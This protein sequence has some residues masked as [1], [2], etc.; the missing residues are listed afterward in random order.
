MTTNH[1]PPRFAI[2]ASDSIRNI[3]LS[4]G[5]GFKNVLFLLNKL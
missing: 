2:A 4:V 5:S 3:S 1:K